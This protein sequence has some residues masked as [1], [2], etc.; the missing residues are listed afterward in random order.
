MIGMDLR[1]IKLASNLSAPRD[2]V[3]VGHTSGAMPRRLI[4]DCVISDI[5]N[6]GAFYMENSSDRDEVRCYSD[7]ELA[8]LLRCSR[9]HIVNLRNRGE[10]RFV[11]IGRRI[12]TRHRD[13]IELLD[14]NT[15][16]GLAA[17]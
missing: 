7:A 11:R 4:R 10:L 3:N 9:R 6:R 5:T 8:K 15:R 12:V 16:G 14:R 13:V 17:A 1:G 2:A